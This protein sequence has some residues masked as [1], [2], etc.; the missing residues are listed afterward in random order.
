MKI[1]GVVW[2]LTLVLLST[3]M[4]VCSAAGGDSNG[5]LMAAEAAKTLL[6]FLVSQ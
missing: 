6:T 4:P 5:E 3:L 2:C 1:V